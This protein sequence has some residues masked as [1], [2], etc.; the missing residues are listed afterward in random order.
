MHCD[1]EP[2]VLILTGKYLKHRAKFPGRGD[3]WDAKFVPADK[4][5]LVGLAAIAVELGIRP[6]MLLTDVAFRIISDWQ[7]M[8]PELVPLCGRGRW[9][10]EE[11][12]LSLHKQLLRPDRV[13]AEHYY[14]C[15]TIDL[16][17]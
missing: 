8:H 3:R 7:E 9:C 13:T 5:K 15:D 14:G 6:L 1:V 11:V 10:D 12:S 17:A 4:N 2:A 16:F